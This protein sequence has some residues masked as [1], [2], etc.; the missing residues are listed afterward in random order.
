MLGDT[1]SL[2]LLTGLPGSGKSLRIAQAISYLVDKGEH[3]YHCNI[4]GLAIKGTTPWP[5]P[6]DWRDLPS[7]AIL[8]VDEAQEFFPARRGGEPPPE[9]M[10]N[11]IR[12]DGIRIVLATQQPNYLDT[13][14][15]GLIGYHEHL[16]RKS[17][18][19]ASFIFRN[20]QVIDEVRAAL[21]RIKAL[22]DYENWKFPKKFFA[23]YNSAQVH[24]VK[25]QMPA[26]VK[27]ALWLAPIAAT[28]AI[29][30]WYAVFRDSSLMKRAEA[31]EAKTPPVAAS[32]AAASVRPGD[33]RA[34]VTT[35][36]EYLARFSPTIVGIPWSAPAW[37]GR[38][39][40][41]DPHVYCMSSGNDGD[42]ACSC[43]TE[44]GTRYE[45]EYATCRR[46][47]RWGEAYNPFKSPQSRQERSDRET[48][49][50]QSPA[51]DGRPAPAPA[52]VGIGDAR[53]VGRYGGMRSP[54]G[55]VASW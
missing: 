54:E 25:Y 36:D 4:D 45:L 16:L 19:E 46:V 44:Q 12:H 38:Q 37:A 49:A 33:V 48:G 23:C 21:P 55:N 30:A 32:G 39:V 20:N 10:M 34:T 53:P 40:Q 17:G 29:G 18:K 2:S 15:R 1:A 41:S 7:G 22:Y 27:R 42:Q 26:L 52:V 35:P 11:R 24:T 6:K 51:Q 50:G 9:V 5:D 14:L 3:V 8:F 43:M 13:H 28:L 31:A 47:A